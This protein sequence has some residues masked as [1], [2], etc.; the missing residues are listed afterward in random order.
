M[1]IDDYNERQD[2][3]KQLNDLFGDSVVEIS[4]EQLPF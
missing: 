3:N 4:N 1:S 2:E